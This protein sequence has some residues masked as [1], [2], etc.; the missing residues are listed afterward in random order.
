MS[1]QLPEAYWA[2]L[3]RFADS[4]GKIADELEKRNEILERMAA[5]GAETTR[6]CREL[7]DTRRVNDALK[8]ID[9]E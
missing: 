1:G 3:L 8:Q 9:S 2:V 5:D 4:V 7:L 6:L